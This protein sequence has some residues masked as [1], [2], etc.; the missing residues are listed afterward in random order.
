M[1][2]VFFVKHGDLGRGVGKT[3][4]SWGG[5]V[6][7]VECKTR[8]K[9]KEAVLGSRGGK[10]NEAVLGWKTNWFVGGVVCFCWLRPEVGEGFF[11]WIW[12]DFGGL[13]LVWCGLLRSSPLSLVWRCAK[14]VE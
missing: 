14:R 5:F 12:G 7:G 6:R 2:H 4:G 1:K 3:W 10:R 13:V 11:G 8:G 9:R